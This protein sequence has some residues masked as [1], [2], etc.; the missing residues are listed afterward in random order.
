MNYVE[1][2]HSYQIAKKLQE[3]H[4]NF[5]VNSMSVY[6]NINRILSVA[7]H[8]IESGHYAASHIRNIAN[9]LERTWKE[10]AAGLDER[11]A[12]LSLSAIFHHK[13]E[14]YVDN[15]Q[16]WNQTCDTLSNLPNEILMLEAALHQHQS[17]YEA[18]CQAY[19]EVTLFFKHFQ[20]HLFLLNLDF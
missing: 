7:G 1:I 5:T 12:V 17:L 19:T 3:D 9:R 11:T 10:F 15:V 18:M 6:V 2:G 13:A 16:T 20:A 4:Q 8:L 14:Q